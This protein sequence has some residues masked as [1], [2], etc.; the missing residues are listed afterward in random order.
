[1]L[2]GFLVV[3]RMINYMISKIQGWKAFLLTVLMTYRKEQKR[4][5]E[6]I[7]SEILDKYVQMLNLYHFHWTVSFLLLL[8]SF[9]SYC[10]FWLCFLFSQLL[11]CSS[12]FPTHTT[13]FSLSPPPPS[14]FNKQTKNKNQNNNTVRQKQNPTHTHIQGIHFML[15]SHFWVC[16][17]PQ[18]VADIL[19]DTPLEK[20]DFPFVA[21]Y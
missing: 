4:K 8:K 21:S 3:Q 12:Q 5:I 7:P 9:F 2:M 10:M 18:S 20:T 11:P 17:L 19:N 13:L 15:A 16:G 14:L 1:M 6:P